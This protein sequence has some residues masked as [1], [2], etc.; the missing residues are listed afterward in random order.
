MIKCCQST[1]NH[2]VTKFHQIRFFNLQKD[3]NTS[4]IIKLDM[5]T[6]EQNNF[7]IFRNSDL[8]NKPPELVSSKYSITNR[9]SSHCS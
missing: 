3:I 5:F 8:S 7:S 2:Q 9:C 4:K 1:R 6:T